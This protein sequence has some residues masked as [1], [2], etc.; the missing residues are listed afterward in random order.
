VVASVTMS[1]RVPLSRWT[2]LPVEVMMEPCVLL[3]AIEF[4]LRPFMLNKP[5]LFDVS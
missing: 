3:V 1:M 4:R 2:F 5:R